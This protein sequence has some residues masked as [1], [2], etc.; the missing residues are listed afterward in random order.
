MESARP[1]VEDAIRADA[2]SAPTHDVRSCESPMLLITAAEWRAM[3]TEDPHAD[4]F[5]PESWLET[6]DPAANRRPELGEQEHVVPA[7]RLVGD[8]TKRR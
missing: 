1:V 7:V 4:P 5:W 8:A 2:A 3:V 6:I